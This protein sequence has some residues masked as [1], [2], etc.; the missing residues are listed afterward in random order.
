MKTKKQKPRKQQKPRVEPII[1]APYMATFKNCGKFYTAE[2]VTALEAIQ[3]LKPEI[4]RGTSILII[5]K[6]G[7]KRE[8]VLGFRLTNQLFGK[9][10]NFN[11]ELG[12]KSITAL[13][14]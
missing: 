4:A 7:I 11:K 1:V 13:L 5:E 8:K 2:G 3:N 6:D 12:I 10:S 14:G 9:V